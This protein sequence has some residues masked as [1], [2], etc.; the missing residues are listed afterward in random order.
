MDQPVEEL[1]ILMLEV[2]PSDAAPQDEADVELLKLRARDYVLKGSLARLAPAI[3]CA[4]SEER[5]IRNR[6][7]AEHMMREPEELAHSCSANRCRRKS[8]K[9]NSWLRLR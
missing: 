3:K 2:D 8:L 6:K 4:M 5:G 9:L 7:L 1:R